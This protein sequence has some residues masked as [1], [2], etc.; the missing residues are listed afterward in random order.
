[1]ARAQSA[2]PAVINVR[3]QT[4]FHIDLGFIAFL[5]L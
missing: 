1:M 4:T 3:F 5:P 2:L